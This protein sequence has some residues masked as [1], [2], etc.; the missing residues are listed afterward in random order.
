MGKSFKF[1]NLLLFLFSLLAWGCPGGTLLAMPPVQRTVLP[2]QMVL[3]V[4]EEHSLPFVTLQ[5]LVKAGSGKDPL[6]QEGLARLTAKGLLLGTARRAARAIDEE[7]DFMGA[8][9]DSS[10]GRDYITLSLRVLKKDLGKGLALFLEV[11]TQPV[12]PQEEIKKEVQKTLAAIQAEEDQPEEVAEKAFEETL[13]LRGPYKYPVEGTKDSLPRITR[14]DIVQFYQRNYQPGNAV[15]AV[16]GDITQAEVKA[17]LLPLLDR[18]PRGKASVTALQNVFAREAKTVKIDRSLTQANVIL[19]QEGVSRDN[20]DYYALMVMNHIL[21]GGGF[22]S[23]LMEEI[24]NKRGLAYSV[25]SFLGFVPDRTPD[26]K[27]LRPGGHLPRPGTGGAHSKRTG[28]RKRT[29]RRQEI[30][31]GQLP[32]APGYPGETGQF[33]RPGG[34]LWSGA[35]LSGKISPTD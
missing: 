24:R 6:G 28:L 26:Q 10:A 5:L 30:P 25:Y 35:G 8:S 21:G 12:F 9:L 19:G 27:Y 13:Y 23:R 22:S 2:N 16:V 7:L 14:G 32:H 3:L 20:S 18:W 17:G 29:G 11:L 34:I 4:A 1:F 33:S 31:G 15:L